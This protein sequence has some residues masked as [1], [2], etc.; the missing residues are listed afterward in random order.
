MRQ[1]QDTC[2]AGTGPNLVIEKRRPAATRH[3]LGDAY[4]HRS[5]ERREAPIDRKFDRKN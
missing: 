2:Y 4:S 3:V 1:R 5:T